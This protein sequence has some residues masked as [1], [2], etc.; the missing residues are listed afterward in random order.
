MIAEEW[1]PWLEKLDTAALADA[2]RRLGLPARFMDAAIKPVWSGARVLGPAYTVRVVPGQGGC[3]A[4]IEA[5]QPGDVIVVDARGRPDAIV[6]GELFSGRA[7]QEGVAG[8]V[9]DGAVRDL[10]GV[11]E[12]GF[13]LFARAVVPGTARWEGDGEH[14][15]PVTMGHVRVYPGDLVFADEMGVM[16][17][18]P[19]WWEK[20]AEAADEIQQREGAK[21]E[22]YLKAGQSST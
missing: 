18:A 11:R 13:P 20:V 21:L 7:R 1:A 8:A 14:Q 9:I 15:V 16:V 22:A 17:V 19:Q 10:P 5:A 4:A 12:L 6:W 2:A 3:G